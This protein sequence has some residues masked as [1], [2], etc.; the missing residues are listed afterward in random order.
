MPPLIH[1]HRG[2]SIRHPDNTIEAFQ[3]ARDESA[4]AVELDVH[5]LADGTLAVHHD[6]DL[7]DGRA[8]R[9][10]ARADMPESVPDLAAVLDVCAGMLV[11]VEIKNFPRHSDYDPDD[12]VVDAVIALL[13]SRGDRDRILF[14]SF[15]DHSLATA[16]RLAPGIPT[17]FL[18]SSAEVSCILDLVA[19]AGN[20]ALHPVDRTVDQALV[21]AAHKRG[22]EVNVWTVNDADRISELAS[23]GVDGIITDDPVLAR[24]A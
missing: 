18:T 6:A 23:Y 21:N 24:K 7:A 20:S 8:L 5:L 10:L 14:S 16:R 11:N 3:A 12:A 4:D 9:D 15:T 1:A 13:R 17:G 19:T 22:L 2:S